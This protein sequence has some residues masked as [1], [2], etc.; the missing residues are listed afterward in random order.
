MRLYIGK[1]NEQT[2]EGGPRVIF[3]DSADPSLKENDLD[4]R[5]DLANH[6]PTGFEWGYGGSGPS[7]LSLALLAD[8]LKD[9]KRALSFYQAFKM[10]HV[11]H[12]PKSI[13]VISDK[14]IRDAVDHIER[15]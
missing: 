8:A 12:F 6:S 10:K 15:G 3:T 4:P 11:A 1:R 2:Q 5:F 13:F 9:D 14:E 7:Q